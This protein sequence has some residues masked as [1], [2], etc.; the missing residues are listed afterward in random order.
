MKRSWAVAAWSGVGILGLLAG[1]AGRASAQGDIGWLDVSSDPVAEIYIDDQDQN[2]QTP[3]PHLAVSAGH[4][5]LR[6]QTTDGKTSKIAFTVTAGKT[7]SLSMK[8]H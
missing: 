2:V 7:T 3:Q 1:L 4:H 6:L 5:R 8:P